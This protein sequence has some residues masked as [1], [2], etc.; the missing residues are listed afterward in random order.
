MTDPDLLTIGEFARASR[1]SPKAL[2]LYGDLGLLVPARTDSHN[3]YRWYAH[4]QLPTARLMALLRGLDLPLSAVREV[5]A[6][7]VPDRPDVFRAHWARAAAEHAR[8]DALARHVQHHLQGDAPVEHFAVQTRQVP[9][10]RLATFTRRVRVADLPRTIDREVPALRAVLEAQGARAAGAPMVIYHGEV[11]ADSDGPIELCLPYH[12]ALTPSG[13]LILREEAAHAEA[14]VVLTRSQFE[15]PAILGAYD[16]VAD[17]AS[18]HG[19]REV[20][21]RLLASREVYPYDWDTAGPDDPAGEVA[22]PY[23]PQATA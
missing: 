21:G 17:Y 9:V 14:F 23:R 6:A 3:G 7:Q 10:R 20:E 15:F 18:A 4:S 19:C 5:V 8:R 22:W 16:A 11:N 13:E 1:L 12:G 2:R